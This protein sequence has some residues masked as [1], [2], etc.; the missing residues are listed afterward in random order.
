MLVSLLDPLLLVLLPSLLFRSYIFLSSVSSPVLFALLSKLTFISDILLFL[1]PS[2]MSSAKPEPTDE[3]ADD[4]VEPEN[5]DPEE[6]DDPEYDLE[7]D[8][9]EEEEY[10]DDDLLP[11]NRDD[12]ND[13][14]EPEEYDDDDGGRGLFGTFFFNVF[15][16][17][18]GTLSD[19]GD[20]KR[21]AC[22]NCSSLE[23]LSA[24]TED[25]DLN[26]G[27]DV[28]GGS[29]LMITLMSAFLS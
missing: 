13:D 8:L 16:F 9:E 15:F 2:G 14:P 10:E 28:N 24:G 18:L 6:Y 5:D 3:N 25:I 27:S 21:S 20:R 4:L 17:L 1:T 7:Y 19:G 11:E 23:L 26:C 12:E 22:S 29:H